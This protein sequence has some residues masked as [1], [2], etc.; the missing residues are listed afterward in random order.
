VISVPFCLSTN[1]S[2]ALPPLAWPVAA[3]RVRQY[4]RLE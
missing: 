2:S 3:I 1:R 4:R